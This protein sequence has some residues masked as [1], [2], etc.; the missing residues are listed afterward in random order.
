MKEFTNKQKEGNFW[1]TEILGFNFLIERAKGIIVQLSGQNN[2]GDI[3]CGS[4]LLINQNMILT[5]AHVL[6][7][8][9]LDKNQIVNGKT[10]EVIEILTHTSVDVGI[11]KIDQNFNLS[12]GVAL[13]KQE[14]LDEILILGYPKIPFSK[15][16]E[17]I[18]QKGEV[19]G[20]IND[21]E[22]NN[23]FLYSTITKPGNSGGPIFN[24]KG[25]IIGIV[26]REIFSKDLEY[27]QVPFYLGISSQEI[28]RAVKELDAN[29]EIPIE[30]YS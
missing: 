5:C 2:D 25:N 30:D 13:S 19:N 27:N 21:F 26:S 24:N 14:G 15:K 11:V 29:I 3:H 10:V 23:Y 1:I 22:G 18:Y 12:D 17:L 16:S 4:G 20:S 9:K 8:M 6:T 7:D 28:T